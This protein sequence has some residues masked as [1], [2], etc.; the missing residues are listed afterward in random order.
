M[1]FGWKDWG[2]HQ[3]GGSAWGYSGE[4]LLR[5]RGQEGPDGKKEA[6]GRSREAGQGA[7][8]VRGWEKPSAQAEC[9]VQRKCC[10]EEPEGGGQILYAGMLPTHTFNPRTW[11]R[12]AALSG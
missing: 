3:E 9:R 6:L 8:C 11:P 12:K 10:R 5:D 1:T 4:L 2:R 7:V